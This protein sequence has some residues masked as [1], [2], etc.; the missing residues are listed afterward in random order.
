MYFRISWPFTKR[1]KLYLV[2][3]KKKWACLCFI[4]L[5]PDEAYTAQLYMLHH[6]HINN[7]V[8]PPTPTQPLPLYTLF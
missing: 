5:G 8:A 7:A 6:K 4:A 2:Y 1:Y 3:K